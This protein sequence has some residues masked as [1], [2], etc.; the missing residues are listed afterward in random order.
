MTWK[1]TALSV[2]SHSSTT[3]AGSTTA[4][5]GAPDGPGTC[6]LTSRSCQAPGCRATVVCVFAATTFADGSPA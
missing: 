1:A 2:S 3:P 5:A 4:V 6:Q